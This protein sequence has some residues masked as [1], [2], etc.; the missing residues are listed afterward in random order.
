MYLDPRIDLRSGRHYTLRKDE[1]RP[2]WFGTTFEELWNR[3]E[4]LSY[5]NR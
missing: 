2:G 5:K 4:T 3:L 1:K